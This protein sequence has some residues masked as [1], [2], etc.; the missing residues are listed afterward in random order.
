MRMAENIAPPFA[1][2]FGDHLAA[3]PC[4]CHR[5]ISLVSP[6]HATAYRLPT[7]EQSLSNLSVRWQRNDERGREALA[8]QGS[9]SEGQCA[10]QLPT[11]VL[12]FVSAAAEQNPR[13]AYKWCQWVASGKSSA[14]QA[15]KYGYL[16]GRLMCEHAV[17]FKH[18]QVTFSCLLHWSSQTRQPEK[19]FLTKK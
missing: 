6:G 19:R 13:Y 3:P 5:L 4:H 10:V 17:V 16:E 9:V 14:V 1:R 15:S 7:S 18:K 11:P 2:G 12:M 8:R